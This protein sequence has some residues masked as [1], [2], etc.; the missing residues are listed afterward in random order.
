VWLTDFMEGTV[1]ASVAGQERREASL[2]ARETPSK[3]AGG[4][5]VALLT[6]L[7]IV[8][9]FDPYGYWPLIFVAFVPMV[10]AQHRILPASLSGIA[11]GIGIACLWAHELSGGL[12]DGGVAWYYQLLP[13]Y[14]GL[15]IAGLAWRSRRYQE[16]TRYRWF[17][18]SFPAAW[19]GLDYLRHLSAVDF[20]GGTWGSPAYALYGQYWLLQPLSVFGHF[21]LQLLLLVVNFAVARATIA[22]I[23][24]RMDGDAGRD[25]R[26]SAWKNL[27]VAVLLLVAWGGMSGI[28]LLA[29]IDEGPHVRVA[30]VQPNAVL[31]SE[32]E[33]RR[34]IETTREAA[35][36]GAQLVVW[37]EGGLKFNPLAERTSQLKTLAAETGVTI[38]MGYRYQ[39]Q[40]GHHNEAVVLTP[41]GRFYGPYGKTHPGRFA[42]DYSDTGGHFEVY[43]TPIGPLATIIC[44][45]LDFTD[46]AREM[47]RLGARIVAVPSADV[48]AIARSHYTHLVF[49]AI[50]NRLAMIKADNTFD[51]AIIDPY[52]RIL[53]LELNLWS[54]EQATANAHGET[55]PALIMA[56]VPPGTADS[57]YVRLGDWV[58]WLAVA[59]MIALV[60]ASRWE[61]VR[62]ILSRSGR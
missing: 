38:A 3:V 1:A 43:E 49:R 19:V 57:M 42:G 6:G 46:T 10:V 17:L 50:E 8:L 22:L 15:L 30:A 20:L 14:I 29:G 12:A 27:A 25:H 13:L 11:P 61:T 36:R 54:V 48:P 44:Y 4:V 35:K 51:S 53:D 9:A 23:D 59:A 40:E 24:S 33:F 58:G 62:R 41:E 60:G 45:D 26:K 47:A 52:G 16:S 37:R 39:S 34:D 7:L 32:E 5:G 56:D 28:Q 55:P 18:I 21:G 31:D 2:S